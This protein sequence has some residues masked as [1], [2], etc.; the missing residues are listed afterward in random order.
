MS[1]NPT[2]TPWI[3]LVI[4]DALVAL[5]G[6]ALLL[7]AQ[8]TGLVRVGLDE[9]AWTAL[10][11]I[12][13]L[14]LR[15]V[16]PPAVAALIGAG[17]VVTGSPIPVVGIAAF[18]VATFSMGDAA[19]S[20]RRSLAG[21]A[22]IAGAVGLWAAVRGYAFAI[23]L[24]YFVSVPAWL[25]G[26]AWR[27]RRM[28]TIAQVEAERRDRDDR[29]RKAVF[30]ERRRLAR[31]LH[32][33]VAH[34]VGVMVVQA[35]GARQVMDRAPDRAKV[36]LQTVEATGR[37][38]LTELRRLLT[39]LA[40][41]RD[42]QPDLEPHPTLADVEP[43]VQRLREAG[44]PVRLRVDGQPRALPEGTDAAA[45]RIV[46]EALTNAMKHAQGAPTEVALKF[47]AEAL[48]VEV[49]DEG[50]PSP[51]SWPGTSTAGSGRGLLGMRERAEA[52]GGTLETG[53]REGHGFGVR[54]RL[55][56]APPP[57]A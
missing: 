10:L 43:M 5:I 23:P 11:V 20:G 48:V 33:V 17:I 13:P 49:V 12:G 25:V 32:D 57:P 38:A 29:V 16:A 54:A 40:D 41:D 36:A 37:E 15:R 27:E 50:R 56:L 18:A 26:D 1:G 7:A 24:S 45:Y 46:Q 28:R 55:P 42:G 34:D 6:A 8:V 35:G 51:S 4:A 47:G 44:L 39:L 19:T 3:P 14:A 2:A 9:V 52:L 53:P 30:D 21:L 22:M 31:E